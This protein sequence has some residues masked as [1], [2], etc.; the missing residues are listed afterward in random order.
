ME[1]RYAY[2]ARA[3]TAAIADGRHPVGSYLPNEND[4]AKQFAVSRSTVRAAMQE[5]QNS[6]LVSRRK[7][8]GTRVEALPEATRAGTFSHTLGSV[9]AVQQ[10]GV[11]TERCIQDVTEV[12]AD[13]ELAARL[14]CRPGQRWLRISFV[15]LIPGD[16]S[17]TPIC[18]TDVYI[19][20]AFSA[21]VQ[22][23]MEGHDAI[24][25][26]LLESISGRS[27]S[28]I[29]QSITAVGIPDDLATILRAKPQSHALAIRRQYILS[30]GMMAEVSLSIHPA[31]RYS[32]Q[33]SMKRLDANPRRA[34][35]GP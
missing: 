2:V 5:L 28:E 25:G 13:D 23:R 16:A 30:P 26:T 19:H 14:G 31:D 27:I 1:T 4:L 8:A 29:R 6:G 33:S 9:E 21:A 11:E 15:R 10:F 17:Q 3:I 12:V 32:Y 20:A 7:S 18:W 35:S 22:A 34:E 24:F